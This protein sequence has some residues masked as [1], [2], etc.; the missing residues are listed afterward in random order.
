MRT[1]MRNAVLAAGA[2]LVCAGGTAQAST[3]TV[4]EANVPFPFAVNQSLREP[5]PA[6]EHLAVW[7]RRPARN[8]PVRPH[9]PNRTVARSHCWSGT[10]PQW[11][12]P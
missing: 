8:R 9:R 1:I 2:I 11:K 5:I 10:L 12:G 4:M 3:S 7:K 6:G